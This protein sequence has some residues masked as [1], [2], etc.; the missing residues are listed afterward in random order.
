MKAIWN[1]PLPPKAEV[2]VELSLAEAVFLRELVGSIHGDSPEA[3][4]IY[5]ALD[6]L[7][8]PE[9]MID[10]SVKASVWGKVEFKG[11][12]DDE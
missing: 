6:D 5:G 9:A 7:N 1:K 11:S 3:R 8:M 10:I 4:E 12:K 2:M